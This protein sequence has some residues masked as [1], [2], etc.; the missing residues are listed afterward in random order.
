MRGRIL[1]FNQDATDEATSIVHGTVPEAVEAAFGQGDVMQLMR[2]E[3]P[4]RCCVPA[5][6]D[7]T[8]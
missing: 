8:W 3:N 4:R 1:P 2:C 6:N 7:C 5:R